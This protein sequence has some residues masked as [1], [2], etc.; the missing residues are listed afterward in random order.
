[1]KKGWLVNDTLTCIPGT[2]TFW[3]DL[4]EWIPNLEDKCNGHT[5]FTILPN[6][7]EVEFNKTKVG[8]IIRN[9]TYFRPLNIPVKT[10]SLLQDLAPN[11]TMQID[12]CNKSDVVVYN[13][14]YTQSH[15][16]DIIT[17]KS[18]MIPLGVNFD[19]FKPTNEDF[20]E[21]LGILPN[22]ILFI[23]ANNISPKGFDIMIEIIN[24]TN[25]NFCL[26]MKDG[27]Q[28]TNSRVKV[29]NR[30]DH[31]KL[32][33]VMNSCEML[34][35]T[36]RVETLHLSGVESAAC[37]LPLVT[38]NVGIYYG[39]E[40]GEWGRNVNSFNSEDFIREIKYVKDNVT[41]FNPRKT[42]LDIGLD[43]ETCKNKWINLIEKL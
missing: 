22:S 30:I 29:F 42:F 10:I 12:V 34:V 17:S 33:K 8:Y 27:Y 19:K 28:S 9:A 37:G 13:S 35:C 39:L 18:V 32:I 31:N 3:H 43:T 11:N 25:Y 26:V 2:K 41:T 23:G 36:S 40:N 7:I 15:Y 21:E 14:P 1:M 20:S 38:S 16:K 4:L 24:N 5:P 6:Y